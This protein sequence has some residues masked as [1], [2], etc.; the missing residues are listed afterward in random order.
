[1]IIKGVVYNE[2]KM[3]KRNKSSNNINFRNIVGSTLTVGSTFIT[4]A[5]LLF[6]NLITN[7]NEINNIEINNHYTVDSYTVDSYFSQ[8]SLIH[9]NLTESI[10]SN[11]SMP[12]NKTIFYSYKIFRWGIIVIPLFL[13]G[14]GIFIVFKKKPVKPEPIDL[15]TEH[16]IDNNENK[17]IK[18]KA[19]ITETDSRTNGFKFDFDKLKSSAPTQV[20][21]I[22]IEAQR[23]RLDDVFSFFN[24]KPEYQ[25]YKSGP[26]TICLEYALPKGIRYK[27]IERLKDEISSK[28]NETN[29]FFIKDSGFGE[30]FGV[31][32]KRN[33]PDTPSLGTYL[34]SEILERGETIP[35]FLGMDF[36]GKPYWI[37]SV[38]LPHLI[39][40]GSNESDKS[41][42]LNSLIVNLLACSTFIPI[43]I[44]MIDPKK[45]EF[46][47]YSKLN[48]LSCR[49]LNKPQSVINFLK[50]LLITMNERY[51][52]LNRKQ[53]RSIQDYNH[54]FEEKNSNYMP[55]IFIF[56]DDFS[57]LIFKDKSGNI[58][59]LI[60][61][62]AEKSRSVGIHFILSAQNVSATILDNQMKSIFQ[63]RISFKTDS[64]L[65]S[66]TILDEPGAESLLGNGDMLYKTINGELERIQCPHIDI[67]EINKIIG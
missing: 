5:I 42:L 43:N 38:K 46:S 63:S 51:E 62:I 37:D 17:A 53:I 18:Q 8:S 66:K 59:D 35:V 67:D 4:V 20:C 55:Y 21:E 27:D 45:T 32:I 24:I 7:N 39:I 22:E 28:M 33:T 56:I 3:K 12:L 11:V 10:I 58:R 29:L 65:D 41:V 14:F 19:L 13:L 9:N 25:G 34:S 2:K 30:N 47:A 49:I 31:L 61:K 48:I 1:M 44:T 15:S 23:V 50:E 60:I 64:L 6:F 54:D 36:K 57:D 26:Q 16:M 40:A 52:I